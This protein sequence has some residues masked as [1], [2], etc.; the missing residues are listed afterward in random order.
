[1]LKDET[2]NVTVLILNNMNVATVPTIYGQGTMNPD[3]R[4]GR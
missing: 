3:E 1:M 2:E 4:D